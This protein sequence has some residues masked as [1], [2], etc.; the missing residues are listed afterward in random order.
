[1][2]PKKKIFTSKRKQHAID[3]HVTSASIN[4]GPPAPLMLIT[5][6]EELEDRLSEPTA[7]DVAAMSALNGDILILGAAGKMARV[8]PN[9]HVVR[10]R[11]P[12]LR[13]A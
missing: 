6:V 2:T 5:T 4:F 1:V 9:W 7:A 10:S 13:S 3:Y 11:S 8:W 12:A